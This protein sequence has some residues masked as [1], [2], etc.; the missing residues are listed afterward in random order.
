[1]WSAP[2]AVS[3][4]VLMWSASVMMC[5]A[6]VMV[7]SNQLV[8]SCTNIDR[9]DGGS[10]G[11]GGDACASA[12]AKPASKK[13]REMLA[14]LSFI[15]FAPPKRA[16]ADTSWKLGRCLGAHRAK[17]RYLEDEPRATISGQSKKSCRR[18]SSGLVAESRKAQRHDLVPPLG[19][20]GRIIPPKAAASHEPAPPGA[21]SDTIST[22]QRA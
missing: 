16:V 22:S 13:N 4:S 18:C 2:V 6:S 5:L 1:M 14:V 9:R 12:G 15:M 8:T 7:R 10:V 19:L 3:S 17:L 21:A 11:S 20:E